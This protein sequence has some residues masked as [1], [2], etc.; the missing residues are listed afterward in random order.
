MLCNP[1]LASNTELNLRQRRWFEPLKDYDC[2]IEY[3]PGKTNVVVE[4]LS[5]KH[6]IDLRAIYARLSLVDD[7]G[8]L[9]KLQLKPTLANEIKAKQPLDVSLLPWIKKVEDK[10]TNDYRFSDDGVLCF[11]GRFCL[12]NIKI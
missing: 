12:S 7:G 6:M 10:K 8:L 4:A 2:V 1:V 3:H 11:R 5:R 9:A